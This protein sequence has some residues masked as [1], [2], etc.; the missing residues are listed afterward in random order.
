MDLALTEEAANQVKKL[1][2]MEELSERCG[3]RVGVKGGGCAGFEYSVELERKPSRFE[4]LRA[5][6]KV[7]VS[8]GV[9]I[10]TDER[11]LLFIRGSTI[12]WQQVNLGHQFVFENPLS[13]GTCG[14][15][16]SFSA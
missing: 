4:L 7:I 9:R 2:K 16:V 8:K 10:I 6:E 12:D 5:G 3:L 14:C 1:L 11:S 13:T 15:G